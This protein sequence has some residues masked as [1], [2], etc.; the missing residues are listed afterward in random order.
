MPKFI[1]ITVLIT[2][3][4]C[5][6]DDENLSTKMNQTAH[7]DISG[8]IF[9]TNNTTKDNDVNDINTIGQSNNTIYTAQAI[10]NPVILG[11]YVNQ[12][13]AG[14]QGQFYQ[15]GDVNDYFA[16]DL[17][18]GQTIILS[19]AN[20]NLLG[21]DLDLGLYQLNDDGAS[22]IIDASVGYGNTEMLIVPAD[23][24][25]FIQVQAFLGF[26]NYVLS[27]GQNVNVT[28]MSHN[29]GSVRLSS[30]FAI[31]E[32]II[33]WNSQNLQQVQSL[34]ANF[35]MQTEG[36]DVS[37][38]MRFKLNLN[39]TSALTTQSTNLTASNSHFKDSN[40]NLKYQTLIALKNLQKRKEISQAYPNY[41]FNALR[42]PNDNLYRYQWNLAQMNLPQAWDM[43]IGDSA[44]IVAVIDTGVLLDHPDLW[45]NIV[46]GYD[47]IDNILISLDGD[48]RDSNP[49]DPGDQV[50]GGSSFHGTHVAGI[51][52]ASGDNNEGIAGVS[53]RTKIMPLRVLGKGGLGTA[54]DTEQAIRFA[55]GLANDSQTLPAQKAD[56]INLSLGGPDIYPAIQELITEIYNTG[57]MIV[58]AAGNEDVDTPFYP[59]SLD[60]VISVSA[61]DINKQR[62]YYS[63]F[64][65]T[66]DVA[67]PGGDIS[68][69]DINGDGMP[70]GILSTLGN[71]INNG[72][73]KQII[74]FTY[75]NYEGTSMAVPH[76][77]GVM[78]LMKAV[79][80]DLTAQD[81]NAML[82][83]GQLTEDIGAIGRDDEF[84]HGLI[85][86]AKAVIAA[87]ESIG[88]IISQPM[89]QLV[90]TPRALN[91]GL[92][93]TNALLT[94]GNGGGGQLSIEKIEN[95]SG[96]FLSIEGNEL[97]SYIVQVN[98]S[99]LN[100]GTYTATIT[101][102]S[103]ANTVEIP[104][105]LQVG[106]PNITG[107]A[108]L[109]YI[110]LIDAETTET[111]QETYIDINAGA[112]SFD[113]GKVA[114]GE[115]IIV[116]GND[117][118]NDG[119][120]CDIGEACGAYLILADPTSI[121]IPS[122]KPIEANFYTSFNLNFLS[123]AKTNISRHG[124]A[125]LGKN[126]KEVIRYKP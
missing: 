89:P 94:I 50:A 21:N 122:N 106:D 110:L 109:H 92:D 51:I 12:P 78:A 53:W 19:V 102:V 30:N 7:Y 75:Y 85:N 17:Q 59:A 14:A 123:I 72:R 5:G 31:D 63:N 91:F 24:H 54:Y 8:Q 13:G 124:F 105:I 79:N 56:I 61:V 67:A 69:P 18:K 10:P 88:N 29:S 103:N 39:Q 9:V 86:A 22:N 38:P 11:G 74:E 76:I 90:V 58:S 47:F 60:G 80:P 32:A 114:T 41:Y 55:A 95:N 1:L 52:A 27:I 97:G 34:A 28:G 120:I 87:S 23:G 48:G 35:N 126:S 113:F 100:M 116:A 111:V 107:D 3:V 125:R 96:G 43:T 66:I 118:N 84:G 68:S 37:R 25:Y 33:K 20:Q 64:G 115:Y 15:I 2:L 83:N 77:A 16:V 73:G 108:G 99:N 82:I 71:E 6:S 42:V 26:S 104:V 40:Q 4:S 119:F 117:F 57:I 93:R 36:F 112:Y 121:T 70:D 45:H 46:P 101:I 62:A 44:V 65:A 49:N 81:F 98:R